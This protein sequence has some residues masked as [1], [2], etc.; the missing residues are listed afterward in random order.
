MHTLAFMKHEVKKKKTC[1]NTAS[2]MLKD[3]TS[4]KM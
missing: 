4:L 2:Q 1:L 3:K